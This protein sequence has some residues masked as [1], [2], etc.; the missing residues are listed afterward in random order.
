MNKKAT[1]F[2]SKQIRET[3]SSKGQQQQA[4]YNQ[5]ILLLDM[6]A[7]P[8]AFSSNEIKKKT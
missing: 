6:I 3:V 4:H 5:Y 1:K 2:Q 8:L 7:A